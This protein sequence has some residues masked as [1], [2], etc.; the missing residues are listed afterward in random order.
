MVR[1]EQWPTNGEHTSTNLKP[2]IIDRRAL[3]HLPLAVFVV[4]TAKNK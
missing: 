4:L 2:H 1:N 3:T